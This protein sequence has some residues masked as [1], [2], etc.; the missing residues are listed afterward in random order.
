MNDD[1]RNHEREGYPSPNQRTNNRKI[2]KKPTE[3]IC[4]CISKAKLQALGTNHTSCLRVHK[5]FDRCKA[6]GDEED[7]KARERIRNKIICVLFHRFATLGSKTLS[8]QVVE[9]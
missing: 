1:A 4:S 8:K 6:T 3:K 2:S 9:C 7:S 5:L